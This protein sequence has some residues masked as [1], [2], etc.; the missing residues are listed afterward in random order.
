MKK[1]LIVLAILLV[2]GAG[3]FAQEASVSGGTSA[4][5]IANFAPAAAAVGSMPQAEINISGA[6]SDNTSVSIQLDNSE[7]YPWDSGVLIDD[8]RVNSSLLAELGIDAPVSVDLTFGYFDTYFSNFSTVGTFGHAF[9]NTT[10]QGYL[11]HSGPNEALAWE[12]N[13]GFGDFGL[14]YWNTW[15][16]GKMA[17]AF[18]GS[19]AGMVS[20]IAGYAGDYSALDAGTIFA[21][22][23]ANID[24]GMA[25]LYIPAQFALGLAGT[26][27]GWGSG[28][29]ASVM[30]MVTVAVEVGGDTANN[31]AFEY[32]VPQITATPVD[33]LEIYAD[34]LVQLPTDAFK[35]VDI[36]ASYMI[37]A[38]KVNSG[39]VIG[40][41]DTY[42]Y[43]LRAGGG[44]RYTVTGTGMYV[45][46]ETSF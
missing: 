25:T 11:Y 31:A 38:L 36:G 43:R 23:S 28:V 32:I 9:W 2:A 4:G 30:D 42:A 29:K 18:Y 8:W 40:I 16:F 17:A 27:V 7:G 6:P 21:E 24:L 41:D 22:A 1:L 34:A 20:F 5:F 19:V 12:W 44:W 14:R 10:A 26:T 3:A 15:Y 35:A 45:I 39:V 46:F 13:I 33:G 37:G